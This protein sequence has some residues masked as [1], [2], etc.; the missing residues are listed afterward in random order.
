MPTPVNWQTFTPKASKKT[1]SAAAWHCTPKTQHHVQS[2]TSRS[3]PTRT[4]FVATVVDPTHTRLPNAAQLEDQPH[5]PATPSDQGYVRLSW[6]CTSHHR[7]WLYG[8]HHG[9]VNICSVIP[10]ANLEPIRMPHLCIWLKTTITF[11][12]QVPCEATTHGSNM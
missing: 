6:N 8:G 2:R 11:G 4:M 1:S 7:L 10:S 9:T 3:H 5:R 12:R